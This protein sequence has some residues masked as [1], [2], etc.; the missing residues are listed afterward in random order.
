MYITHHLILSLSREIKL[1]LCIPDVTMLCPM[2]C[3]IQMG[4]ADEVTKA[5]TTFKNGVF[6][7]E[8][9]IVF[10]SILQKVY[11]REINGF[12]STAYNL[13]S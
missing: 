13:V 6:I 8:H 10:R 3:T 11:I 9:T 1:S 5:T 4:R 12:Y 2:G 7:L